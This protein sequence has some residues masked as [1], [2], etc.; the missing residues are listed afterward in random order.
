MENEIAKQYKESSIDLWDNHP[1]N[2][3]FYYTRT[4]KEKSIVQKKGKVNYLQ[5]KDCNLSIT[6]SHLILEDSPS[7]K[8][9][10]GSTQKN[11]N[12]IFY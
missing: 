2:P 3:S 11:N 4:P 12:K 10:N 8:K 5:K 9:K 1:L 6:S 7:N